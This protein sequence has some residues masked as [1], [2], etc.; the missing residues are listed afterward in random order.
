MYYVGTMVF[1][2]ATFSIPDVSQGNV[3]GSIWNE[4]PDRRTC[5]QS[6]VNLTALLYHDV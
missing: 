2:G 5:H 4:Q 6:T 1:V 3:G